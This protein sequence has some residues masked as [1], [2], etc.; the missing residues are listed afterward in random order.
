MLEGL[1]EN[2][3]KLILLNRIRLKSDRSVEEASS[4]D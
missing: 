2:D 1:N 4:I 3:V